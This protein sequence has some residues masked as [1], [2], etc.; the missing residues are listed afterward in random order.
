MK[1]VSV[2]E[3]VQIE[4]ESDAKGHTYP[5]MMEHAGRGLA[6][7][8]HK[9]Y[10]DLDPRR[11]V[12]LVGSGNNG[13]DALVALDYLSSWGWQVTALIVHGREE[14]DPLVERVRD[15]G[16]RVVDWDEIEEKALIRK[17]L[18][19]HEV[20]LD[21]VLGTGIRL[22]V[23]GELGER[24]D[25]TRRTLK[26]M[27]DPPHVVAVDCPSGVE[28]D[29]GEVDPVCIPAEVTVT[30]AAVKQ[31]LLKFPAFRFLGD[32]RVVDIGLPEGL[33]SYQAV[34]REVVGFEWVKAVLPER[35][36]DSH[37]GTFG[38]A[39]IVGGSVHYTGAVVLSALGAY[40]V[41]AGLVTLAVPQ[42][43]H[44]VLAGALP[45][46]TWLPLPHQ[47]G[48]ISKQALDTLLGHLD[49][50]EA[51]LIGPGFGL[52]ASTSEFLT[53][54]L[55]SDPLP[56]MVLDADGLKLLS[57]IGNW[58]GQL[59]SPSVLTPHPGEMSVMTG[60]GIDQIQADRVGVAERF[61][62]EWGHVV[63]LK[64]A[65]TVIASPEGETKILPIATP[66]LASAGTGDVLAG[67]IVGLIAEGMDPFQ[68]ASAG[69]WIH[70]QAGLT[71]ADR[72]G[73]TA[74]VLAGDVADS[75]VDVLSWL[76]I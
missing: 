2:E 27:A 53:Y 14:G 15:A 45:E 8:V 1:Y 17:E 76:D 47:D 73:N 55:S 43:L 41:G 31:G 69:A 40:R 74:S 28:T 36:L 50:A 42:P 39:F 63:V 5:E 10:G 3:I 26:E 51:L 7:V 16:G 67:V 64:G 33:A 60:L 4:K 48:F 62:R 59:P 18:S 34:Q 23:R 25:F 58:P 56:P 71:A 75:L 46:T 72:L 6:E 9:T 57:N 38:T 24:L 61:A 35:P 44:A 11:V 13:G 19:V 52:Q 29:T 49:R 70:G 65:H 30:M 37:K 66:A 68:A 20:L 54:L 21:G 22:P 32:L 12:A